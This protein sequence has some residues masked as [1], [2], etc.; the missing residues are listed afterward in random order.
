[1]Y[2]ITASHWFIFSTND[3]S[4]WVTAGTQV[5]GLRD[6]KRTVGGITY[7]QMDKWNWGETSRMTQVPG[8]ACWR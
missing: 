8:S 7:R 5:S 4:K 6:I 3:R 2:K 1:M